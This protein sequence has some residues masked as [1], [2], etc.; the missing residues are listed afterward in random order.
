MGFEGS[1]LAQAGVAIDLAQG[2]FCD[3]RE[4]DQTRGGACI[5]PEAILFMM[6]GAPLLFTLV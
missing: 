6:T 1:E 3:G 2:V 4:G 5:K